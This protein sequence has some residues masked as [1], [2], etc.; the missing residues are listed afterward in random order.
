MP[1]LLNNTSRGWEGGGENVCAPRSDFVRWWVG[2]YPSWLS[3]GSLFEPLYDI[4]SK[5]FRFVVRLL[6]L[7][8]FEQGAVHR[9]HYA[10]HDGHRPQGLPQQHHAEGTNMSRLILFCFV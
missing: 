5:H 10:R 9:K 3:D 8:A 7:F 2:W 6:M 4:H 1:Y